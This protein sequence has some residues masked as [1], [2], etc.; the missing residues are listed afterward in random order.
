M[1]L[2][3]LLLCLC[4]F[5]KEL[6]LLSL[7]F[8]FHFP[9]RLLEDLFVLESGCKGMTFCTILQTI[10]QE[11]C[12]KSVILTVVHIS[13]PV[14]AASTL[15]YIGKKSAFVYGH[16]TPK[17]M[18]GLRIGRNF[19][20]KGRGKGRNGEVKSSLRAEYRSIQGRIL[21]YS[22]P[23]TGVFEPEYSSTQDRILEY[24]GPKTG[25]MREKGDSGWDKTDLKVKCFE[26][27]D[28]FHFSC[29]SCPRRKVAFWLRAT[30]GVMR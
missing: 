25:A 6:F 26:I 11:I 30:P 14:F 27:R 12:K 3:V 15:I 16:N 28:G 19:R 22:R 1:Q 17:S 5:L 21:E 24:S 29:K 8:T 18:T 7:P 20:E 2:L 9:W 13:N 10:L 4:K 23:N